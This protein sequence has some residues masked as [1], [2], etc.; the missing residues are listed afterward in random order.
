MRKKFFR[1]WIDRVYY[2]DPGIL[3]S[4]IQ[5]NENIFKGRSCFP[6]N[7]WAGLS[8]NLA[9]CLILFIVSYLLYKRSFF[10][11]SCKDIDML[12]RTNTDLPAGNLKILKVSGGQLNQY[13]FNIL[14]GK[15]K[16]FHDGARFKGEL[17]NLIPDRLQ[18][19]KKKI[20][21][22]YLCRYEFIPAELR[23]RDFVSFYLKW[24][25]IP[26]KKR[27]S[28]FNREK[29][30]PILNKTFNEL[31]NHETFAVLLSLLQIKERT[32]YLINDITKEI[33]PDCNI[34]LKHHMEELIKKD[35]H[36]IF[37]TT[38]DLV[39]AYGNKSSQ[40]AEDGTGWLEMV[41]VQRRKQIK[42]GYSL[43]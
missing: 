1:F 32:V 21:F 19:G 43:I 17:E 35:A 41:E 15:K 30:K 24:E 28:L 18:P 25:Q 42:T 26:G 34:E 2:H 36:I 6:G 27:D 10:Y 22:L 12:N 3:V 13:L 29:I 16:S 8:I 11:L 23:V 39:D 20:D 4:F 14:S 37:M 40:C 9:Y 7:L 33:N 31:K 5:G 38:A